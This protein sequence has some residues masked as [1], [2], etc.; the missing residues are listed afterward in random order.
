MIETTI[1]CDNCQRE[2]GEQNRW[3]VVNDE[4]QSADHKP[5]TNL[6]L[7]EDGGFD[8][9]ITNRPLLYMVPFHLTTEAEISQGAHACSRECAHKIIEQWMAKTESA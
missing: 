9:C 3:W 6:K 7:R 4:R 8:A 2:K 1:T 5:V